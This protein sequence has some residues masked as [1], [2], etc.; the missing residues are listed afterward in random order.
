MKNHLVASIVLFLAA[1]LVDSAVGQEKYVPRM[2]FD[3][4]FD[5]GSRSPYRSSNGMPGPGYWQN[6]ADYAI[7]ARLD[8]EHRVISATVRV[9]YTQ[10]IVRTVCRLCGSPSTRI[11]CA[12]TLGARGFHPLPR[13]STAVLSFRVLKSFCMARNR[14][15]II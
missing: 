3:P 11:N 8:E 10:T 5:S 2:A 14:K 7:D 9:T 1:T 15:G 4:M 6:R 13:N 12:Q